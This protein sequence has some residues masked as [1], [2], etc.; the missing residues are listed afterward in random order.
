MVSIIMLSVLC[1]VFL[2]SV[3]KVS[4]IMHSVAML[5][6]YAKPGYAECHSTQCHGAFFTTH[7]FILHFLL[8]LTSVTNSRQNLLSL[9]L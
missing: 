7:T 3:I 4:G 2:L 8:I 5:C 1:S 9:P 6:H